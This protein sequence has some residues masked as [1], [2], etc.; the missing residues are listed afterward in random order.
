VTNWQNMSVSNAGQAV[1]KSCC[2]DRYG[3]EEGHAREIVKQ[4]K[5]QL[6]IGSG[7]TAGEIPRKDRIAGDGC[8]KVKYSDFHDHGHPCH[9]GKN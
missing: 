4:C 3:K 6:G 9:L 5:A 8:H 2:P 7:I 1:Q